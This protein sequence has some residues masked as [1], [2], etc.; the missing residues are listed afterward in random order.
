MQFST[1]QQR[2]NVVRFPCHRHRIDA[3]KRHQQQNGPH[4]FTC[5]VHACN[6]M[7]AACGTTCHTKGIRTGN[8]RKG[9]KELLSEWI[10][11]LQD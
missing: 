6:G 9:A 4:S 8:N 7:P 3:A 1:R 5:T 2:D 11:V 10:P